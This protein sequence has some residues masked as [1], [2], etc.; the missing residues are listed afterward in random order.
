MTCPTSIAPPTASDVW[1]TREAVNAPEAGVLMKERSAEGVADG[2]RRLFAALPCRGATRHHA[3][4][5]SWDA[6]TDGQL[7]L[8]RHIVAGRQPARRRLAA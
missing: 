5:F 6:T 8:F 3:E 1:G 2:V 4:H 7:E